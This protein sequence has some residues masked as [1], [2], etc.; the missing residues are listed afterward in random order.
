MPAQAKRP[1]CRT[2][3]GKG[4]IRGLVTIARVCPRCKGRGYVETV[5]EA[6]ARERAEVAKARG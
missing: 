4:Q 5:H 2:C 6:I 3:K 1:P